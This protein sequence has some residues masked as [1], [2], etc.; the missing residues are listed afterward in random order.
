MDY[1]RSGGA[2]ANDFAWLA[3]MTLLPQV[4]GGAALKQEEAAGERPVSKSSVV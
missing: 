4:G 3:L 1:R 2:V